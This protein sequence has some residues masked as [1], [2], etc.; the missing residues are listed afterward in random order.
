MQRVLLLIL[1]DSDDTEIAC[2]HAPT[3]LILTFVPEVMHVSFH[4]KHIIASN[5][6]A[7]IDIFN[8]FQAL[9]ITPYLARERLCQSEH[10]TKVSDW[11]TMHSN[12]FPGVANMKHVVKNLMNQKEELHYSLKSR[13]YPY[14]FQNV[15]E[16]LQ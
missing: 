4:L 8:V 13:K 9:W 16:I 2:N 10:W 1:S 3:P 6:S 5:I 15:T 14:S 12:V 11:Y 7:I